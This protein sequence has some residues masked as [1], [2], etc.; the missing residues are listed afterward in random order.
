MEMFK[1][2]ANCTQQTSRN[3]SDLI[4]NFGK[5]TLKD[6]YL[7]P[8]ES[9]QDAFRRVAFYYSDSKEHGAR[10]YHYISNLWFMPSTPVLSNGGAQRG[11]PISCFLNE[12]SDSLEG[13]LRL[14]EENV[15][16]ASHG[17]GIGSYWGNLR[18]IGEDIKH[19]KTTGIIPFIK[20]MDSLTLAISQGSLRRGS[21]A[22]Y[23]QIDHPEIEE[24]IEIR[25]PTGGD[26]TRKALNVHHGVVI[27]DAFMDA[28]RENKEWA[29]ISPATNSVIRT[30]NAR[31]L[32]I[33]LLTCRL[34]TG[35]PYI[36][37]SDHVNS[38]M[39]EHQKDLGLD[40]KMSNLCSE[41]L[42]PTGKDHLGNQRTAVCCLSSLNLEFFDQWGSN[43]QIIEDCLRFLDNVLDD[44]IKTAPSSMA[45][46]VYSAQRERSI[47]LGVMGWH[48]FLQK[49]MVPF[50]SATAK[51]W[52]L[53]IFQSI[54]SQA[55]KASHKLA[56]E[57][58]PCL[59]AAEC[60]K[61]ERFS[62]IIA[63]APTAS[64]SIICG[65]TSPG[66]EPRIA[67]AY[68]HKTLTG[69]FAVKNPNLER[70]LE[71]LNKNTPDV[72]TNI[73]AHEGSVQQLDFL[74][75]YEKSVFKTAF[76]MDQRWLIDHAADRQPF[77]CQA[78]SLNLFLPH[79]IHK[80]QLHEV[81]MRAWEKKVK[82]LYYLRSKSAQRA[83]SVFSSK[84]LIQDDSSEC[85]GC[86]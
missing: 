31:S 45:R 62:H 24:F 9:I 26:S 27:S 55:K 19:G 71:K 72:W 77:I 73:F 12:A 38:A 7:L 32:W 80:K 36:I 75:A 3:V 8:G 1:K 42:L 68:N 4:S 6:R 46:A 82:T 52:N 66:I 21:A 30:V 79:N 61:M 69:S 53:K 20:V 63:V 85:L 16:L 40:V 60:K 44:F 34:E 18:S 83:E 37:F 17:G 70:L 25:K 13:I 43:P 39:C 5:A 41:I 15:W 23:L 50:E 22:I 28:V 47:G 33:R 84:E 56:I 10:M 11:L 76:E 48:S 54:H 78:Q 58:G 2:E 29:L 51:A 65:E 74:S 81:H 14:W 64:I 67:N 57:K 59:D 49:K 35:E 86:Q